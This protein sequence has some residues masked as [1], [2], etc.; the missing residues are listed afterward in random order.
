MENSTPLPPKHWYDNLTR[1][2]LWLIFFP[3][4]GIYGL[5]KSNTIA[6]WWRVTATLIYAFVLYVSFYTPTPQDLAASGT[7]PMAIGG[8]TTAGETPLSEA[9]KQALVEEPAPEASPEPEASAKEIAANTI[10]ARQLM[11]LY[12]KNEVRAD[13]ALKGKTFYVSGTVT[14]ISKDLSDEIFVSLEGDG[15][16]RSIQCYFNNEDAAA[17]LSKGQKV[18]FKGRC[19]G[20]MMNVMMKDC[21]LVVN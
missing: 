2:N 18:T 16:F 15:T 19:E 13:K 7:A 9:D 6:T 17:A 3:P 21:T 12:M 11:A 1:V 4:A 10:G 20:L 8:E 5:W 14:D